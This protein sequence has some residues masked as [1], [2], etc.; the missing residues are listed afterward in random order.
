MGLRFYLSIVLLLFLVALCRAEKRVALVVG[1]SSY[2]SVAP[3]SNPKNAAA[4]IADTLR[5]AGFA[6]IGNR[7]QLD[8]DKAAFDKAIQSFGN[9]LI[10]ADV[11][12]FYYA[13]HGIQIR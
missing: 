12:L 6:L 10:G 2:P 1:H 11:A 5:S 7:P 9:A 3:L 8:L 13:G 4:L